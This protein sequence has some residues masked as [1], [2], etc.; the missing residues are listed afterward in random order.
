MGVLTRDPRIARS[1]RYGQGDRQPINSDRASR[2][3]AA[4]K[5]DN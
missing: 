3:A 4:L 5:F 1:D 2:R